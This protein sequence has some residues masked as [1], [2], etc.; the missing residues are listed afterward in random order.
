[1]TAHNLF[2]V[3]DYDKGLYSEQQISV[4][5]RDRLTL[6]ALELLKLLAYHINEA[7]KLREGGIFSVLLQPDFT[8]Y[9]SVRVYYTPQWSE[10]IP[11]FGPKVTKCHKTALL[12]QTILANRFCAAQKCDSVGSREFCE[13]QAWKRRRCGS[14]HTPSHTTTPFPAGG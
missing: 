12:A 14:L 4:T 13:L 8:K 3:K 11:V 9:V 7:M 5:H 1:M 2:D 6:I 10:P